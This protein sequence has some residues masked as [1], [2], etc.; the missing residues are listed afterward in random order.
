MAQQQTS[1]SPRATDLQVIR[2]LITAVETDTVYRDLYL[3]RAAH[4][5]QLNEDG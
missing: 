1:D 4:Q 5:S 3:Q 2:L